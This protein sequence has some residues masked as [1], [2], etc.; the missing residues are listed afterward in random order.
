MLQFSVASALMFL[1]GS[2][3]NHEG[4]QSAGYILGILEYL[5]WVRYDSSIE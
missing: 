1:M 2:V 4:T 5:S 3:L